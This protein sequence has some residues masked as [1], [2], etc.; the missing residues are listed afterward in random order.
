[1][2]QTQSP[3]LQLGIGMHTEDLG[4]TA[5]FGSA[6]FSAWF[7]TKARRVHTTHRRVANTPQ[8]SVMTLTFVTEDFVREQT[9]SD[10]ETQGK[11]I[12]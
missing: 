2:N 11:H 4:C 8:G 3:R 5:V 12:H 10:T 7:I 6:V 1:M 9:E